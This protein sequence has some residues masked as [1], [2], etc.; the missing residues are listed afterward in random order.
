MKIKSALVTQMSGSVGGVTGAHNQGGLYFRARTIP[1]NPATTQQQ[2]VRNALSTLTS[3]WSEVLSAE[4]RDAWATYNDQ[5][6]ILDRLGEPRKIG[7]LGHYVRANTPRLQAG[8][9]TVDDGPTTFSLPTIEGVSVSVVSG[10]PPDLSVTFDD[11]AAWV[12]EDDAAL[13]IYQSREQSPAINFF[14]GPYRYATKIEGSS[15]TPPTTPFSDNGV[16]PL[17]GSN[18]T[19]FQIR[20]TRADGRLSAPLRFSASE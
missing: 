5:V 8:L 13:L 3:R 1:V 4:Q 6:L 7:A 15:G 12:T 18:K 11:T 17:S 10:T 19:F 16:F 14:K 2:A 9:A 20:L